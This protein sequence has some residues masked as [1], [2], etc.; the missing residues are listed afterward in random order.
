M[1]TLKKLLVG[2]QNHISY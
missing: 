1:F 2:A